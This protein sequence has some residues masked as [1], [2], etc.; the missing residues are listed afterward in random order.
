[1]APRYEMV[2]GME[3]GKKTTKIEA[4]PAPVKSKGACTKHSKAVRDLVR[5]SIS[6]VITCNRY[7]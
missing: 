4:A 7:L 3:K 5:I 6:N 1:M 2:V